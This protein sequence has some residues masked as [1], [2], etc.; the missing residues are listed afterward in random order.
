MVKFFWG[1]KKRNNVL[2]T[3]DRETSLL[4]LLLT[5]DGQKPV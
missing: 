5:L 3:G 1:W 2:P 4:E